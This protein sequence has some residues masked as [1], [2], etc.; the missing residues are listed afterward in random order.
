MEPL[1]ITAWAWGVGWSE[2]IRWVE[3]WVPAESQRS[4]VLLLWF[5][6]RLVPVIYLSFSWKCTRLILLTRDARLSCL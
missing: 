2:S 5:E 1:L 4:A 3:S 6:P